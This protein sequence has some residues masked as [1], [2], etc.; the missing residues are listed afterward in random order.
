[1]E[2]KANLI[3][4]ADVT[5]AELTPEQMIAAAAQQA[6]E[7]LADGC[8]FVLVT[9]KDGKAQVVAGCDDGT[10]FHAALAITSMVGAGAIGEEALSRMPA[11]VANAVA[12]TTG[13][14]ALNDFA[15][16]MASDA[17]AMLTPGQSKH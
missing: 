7:A 8:Q 4:V 17:G 9:V 16:K 5:T 10:V 13:L 11:P 3:P 2:D 12:V 14:G 15:R 6:T 1:M